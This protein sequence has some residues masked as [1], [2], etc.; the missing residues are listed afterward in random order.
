MTSSQITPL[1]LQR[2]L[3]A[4]RR[5]GE[6]PV[7]MIRYLQ[8]KGLT[9]GRIGVA[10]GDAFGLAMRDTSLASSWRSDGTGT[11]DDLVDR[12]LG[13]A[14]RE[15]EEAA[16]RAMPPLA[17]RDAAPQALRDQWNAGA[18]PCAMVRFLAAHGFAP[19]ETGATFHEAFGLEAKWQ[20]WVSVFQERGMEET[21]ELTDRRVS[22]AI[23]ATTYAR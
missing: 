11:A 22:E 14:L 3:R 5:R 12:Q 13:D 21:E 20:R 18:T 8:A 10:L 23:Q 2:D 17:S 4:M 16:R 15:I 6:T 9:P 19:E 7:Q 1:W